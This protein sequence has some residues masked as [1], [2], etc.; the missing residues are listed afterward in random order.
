MQINIFLVSFGIEVWQQYIKRERLER[1]DPRVFDFGDT[2][3]LT[4]KEL[5]FLSINFCI[6][7]QHNLAK[8]KGFDK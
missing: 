5:S 8:S 6:S 1:L 3:R 4:G 2:K 7:V